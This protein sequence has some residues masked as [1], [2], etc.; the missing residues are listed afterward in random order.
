MATKTPLNPDAE[1]RYREV[2]SD[3]ELGEF[4]NKAKPTRAPYAAGEVLC[5][6]ATFYPKFAE[7]RMGEALCQDTSPCA[8]RRATCCEE[9][10]GLS[11]GQTCAHDL[12]GGSC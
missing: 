4:W 2:A 7:V 11:T 10:L 12:V 8:A 6:G 9:H 1:K 3:K 5:R